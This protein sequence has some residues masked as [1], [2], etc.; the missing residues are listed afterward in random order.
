MKLPSVLVQV[1]F[2][3]QLSILLSHSLISGHREKVDH[4][5]LIQ[6]L[7]YVIT[8]MPTSAVQPIPIQLVASVTAAVEAANSVIADLFT[9][10]IAGGTLINI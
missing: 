3:R 9:S 8:L 10:S 6:F 5:L 4:D 2:A 1:A 7:R